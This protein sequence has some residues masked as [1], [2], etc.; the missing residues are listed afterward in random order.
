[1]KAIGTA[2]F[3]DLDGLL[4]WH[5]ALDKDAGK[6][7][8]GK[9]REKV[10]EIFPEYAGS[11]K[12]DTPAYIIKSIAK[13]MYEA[14]WFSLADFR[15]REWEKSK[16]KTADTLRQYKLFQ[17]EYQQPLSV[18]IWNDEF[19]YMYFGNPD[20]GIVVPSPNLYL[21]FSPYKHTDDIPV[22]Q[23]RTQLKDVD[24]GA[25]GTI[26]PA[27]ADGQL[28][29]ASLKKD[30][31][32]KQNQLEEMKAQ[33]EQVQRGHVKEL[34]AIQAEIDA[35]QQK[36]YAQK[37]SLMADLEDKMG[38]M[39]EQVGQLEAQIYLLDSQIYAI[40]CLAGEVVN[41]AHIR[42]GQNAPE[43]EPIVIHQK[44]RF[45]DEELGRMTSIY[46][47]RWENIRMFEEFLRHSPEALETF[48]PNK[49]CVSL[50][51]VSKSNTR[52][53]RSSMVPYSNLLQTYEYFHG[54][55]VGI[56][57]RNGDNLYLGWT[58]ENR[59]HIKDDFII[60]RVITEVTPHEG[61]E[62]VFHDELDEK[63]RQRKE[64]MKA[65]EE[66]M[67]AVD[68]IISRA[69]V[70]NILQGVVKNTSWLPLPD[71]IKIS[72]Q[73][74]YVRFALS[75]MC[76]E[77]HR[78][79]DFNQLVELAN[80][81]VAE[82][83]HLLMMQHLRA[84]SNQHCHHD[85]GRGYANRTHDCAAENGGI[86]P[87]NL[88]EYTE[89]EEMAVVRRDAPLF[90]E[91][92]PFTYIQ[93]ATSPIG[94]DEVLVRRF[95]RVERTIYISLEKQ[96]RKYLQ[97]KV[98]RANFRVDPEEFMNLAWMNSVWLTWAI[99]T[100][101]LGNWRLKGQSVEYAHAI[102]YLN[103]ALEDVRE[104]EAREKQAIDAVDPDICKNPDWPLMLSDWKFMLA[105]DAEKRTVRTIT[106][107]Q[108]KRFAR[109]VSEG[110]PGRV[111]YGCPGQAVEV[112]R[113]EV[114]DAV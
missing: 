60:S 23:I 31:A 35:L 62:E 21:D 14:E 20:C 75:D 29:V 55:T 42:N 71:G 90:G 32:A 50:V 88:V 47:I 8:A 17:E 48:A 1:M 13:K 96:E 16:K 59:V 86:Y 43:T 4:C 72:Q 57:I 107:F 6:A 102:R 19:A 34:E 104:R 9:V 27:S 22:A 98:P 91:D 5:Q 26:L 39:E 64:R 111:N 45:L 37:Q 2:C 69:F 82:G 61:R 40:R 68:A 46:T 49:R 67:T 103:I 24:M 18:G 77:D 10:D 87:A 81:D 52:I 105:N 51:R 78:F 100:K 53:G 33:M 56:I 99:N 80:K 58:D 85:R 12:T 108:A 54:R 3:K 74:P 94:K 15:E 114:F 97:N 41:F 25:E 93:S 76:L 106:P 109:W 70:F 95:T 38:D 79:A 101:N 113:E 28:T 7:F 63:R 92:K 36:L 65:R 112:P 110:M 89:P 73:S 44:L 30:Q 83:D 84:Y 11:V 66:R